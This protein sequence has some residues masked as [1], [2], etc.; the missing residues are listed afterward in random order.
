MLITFD[1]QNNGSLYIEHAAYVLMNMNRI[2]M[3]SV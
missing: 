1:L 3:S 2:T